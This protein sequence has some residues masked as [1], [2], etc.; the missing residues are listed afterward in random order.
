MK[1]TQ[2]LL[3]ALFLVWACV[4]CYEQAELPPTKSNAS[5]Y[6]KDFRVF[7]GSITFDGMINEAAKS[8]L[9]GEWVVTN[10]KNVTCR[11]LFT[12]TSSAS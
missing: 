10:N 4:G 2:A 1:R 5:C 9:E 6:Y 3:C 11:V 12:K 8:L 7:A